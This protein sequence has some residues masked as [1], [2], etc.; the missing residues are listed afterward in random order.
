MK[1]YILVFAVLLL[2]QFIIG[3]QQ[4][5]IRSVIIDNNV[6]AEGNI[7]KDTLYDGLIKFYDVN[8]NKLIQECTYIHGVENGHSIYYY[9]T[10]KISAKSF[11]EN[12]KQNGYSLFYD[13][14]GKLISKDFFYHGI[15][16]GSSSKYSNNSISKYW[17]YS[18]DN[19]LLFYIS[20]DSLTSRKR[21]TEL[22]ERFFFYNEREYSDLA[23]NEISKPKK[24]FFI[25]TPNPP[26]YNFRYSLVLTDNKYKKV[27]EVEKFSTETPWSVFT[28]DE[29]LLL[30]NDERYA[31][32]LLISDS[33]S[34]GDITMYKFLN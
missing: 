12:G 7:T 19:K 28:V 34:G 32:R 17:F 29:N 15:R 16:A 30:N 5:N 21:I 8:S 3:C 4:K 31:F 2:T 25:Y 33:V 1:N 27:T 11:F 14:D 24:E 20:Y 22:Q 26:K 18:L 6:R 10:G 23:F 13:I 9:K